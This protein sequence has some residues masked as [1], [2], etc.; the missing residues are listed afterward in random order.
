MWNPLFTCLTEKCHLKL[1]LNTLNSHSWSYGLMTMEAEEEK[2]HLISNDTHFQWLQNQYKIICPTLQLKN[3]VNVFITNRTDNMAL[4]MAVSRWTQKGPQVTLTLNHNSWSTT[5]CV[6][7]LQTKIGNTRICRGR[8][9]LLKFVLTLFQ[10]ILYTK[11]TFSTR[12]FILYKKITY[13][14]FSKVLFCSS[15]NLI[16]KNVTNTV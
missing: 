15:D 8:D 11:N 13:I 3:V 12:T 1:H 9:T 16:H 2:N 6:L 7:I 14:I 5:V 4:L 10:G